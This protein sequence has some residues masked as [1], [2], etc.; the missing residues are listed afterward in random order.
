MIPRD[1]RVTA[2]TRYPRHHS[3]NTG[4]TLFRMHGACP[5]TARCSNRTTSVD[6]LLWTDQAARE[7][8]P[9]ASGRAAAKNNR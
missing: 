9:D 2:A 1:Y 8:K 3:H 5:T 6:Q 4:S 7:L